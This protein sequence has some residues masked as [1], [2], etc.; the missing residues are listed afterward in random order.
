LTPFVLSRFRVFLS[1]ASS[2]TQQRILTKSRFEKFLQKKRGGNPKPAFPRFFC[3]VFGR[4]SV[5]GVA[6][7]GA[8]GGWGGEVAE[9]GGRK[10]QGQARPRKWLHPDRLLAYGVAARAGETQHVGGPMR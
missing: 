7:T 8:Q 1:N 6:K 2:K 5:R 9:A 4:F 3:H 10:N